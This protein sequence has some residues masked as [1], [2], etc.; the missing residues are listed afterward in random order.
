MLAIAHQLDR[1]RVADLDR[2]EVGLL[3]IAVDPEGIGVD[4]GNQVLSDGRVIAELRQKIGH[5]AVDRRADLGA[6]QI[7]LRLVQVGDGLLIVAWAAER[8]A[9]KGLLLLDS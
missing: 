7:D 8:V 9:S 6:L 5:V 3:E 2:V 1:G 4:Q